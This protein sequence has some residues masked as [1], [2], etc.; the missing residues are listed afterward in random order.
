MPLYTNV[1]GNKMTDE[2]KPIVYVLFIEWLT[3]KK[4]VQNLF[5]EISMR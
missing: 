3:E 2:L 1:W 5:E 4:Y